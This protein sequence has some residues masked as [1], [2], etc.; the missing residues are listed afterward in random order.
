MCAHFYFSEN[1]STA[2]YI[3]YIVMS[4][5]IDVG[6]MFYGRGNSDV[7]YSLPEA[8]NPIYALLFWIFN[9][10]AFYTAASA[11]LIRFGNDLLKWIRMRRAKI[12]DV[13]LVFAI[14]SNS[15]AFGRNI[16][17][18]KGRMLVYVDSVGR[19]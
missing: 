15:I 3:T 13:D 6:I 12:S 18:S 16:A 11:L 19:P 7:F 4:P 2:F 1:V 5:V 14:N 10:L 9:A 8:S 17:D